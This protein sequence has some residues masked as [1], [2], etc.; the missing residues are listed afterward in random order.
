MLAWNDKIMSVVGRMDEM[1]ILTV[2]RAS[3]IVGYLSPSQI[4]DAA[5][6]A[7]TQGSSRPLKMLAL[8]GEV[9][10]QYGPLADRTASPV[11]PIDR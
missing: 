8:A 7:H 5:R 3:P 10:H 11:V 1:H 2:V 6:A 9:V 4:C